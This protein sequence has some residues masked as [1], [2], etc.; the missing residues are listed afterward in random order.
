MAARTGA[1]RYFEQRLL[2][3]TYSDAHRR[4]T[5]RI[6]AVDDARRALASGGVEPK[7]AQADNSEPRSDRS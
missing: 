4:A 5:A 7:T 3:P 1:T 6:S 2:D